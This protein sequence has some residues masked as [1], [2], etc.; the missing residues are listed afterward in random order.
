MQGIAFAGHR[1]GTTTEVE[2][3]LARAFFRNAL[4]LCA[5]NQLYLTDDEQQ[6][7][8]KWLT[9]QEADSPTIMRPDDRAN[10]E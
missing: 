10:D 6:L 5:R 7:V 4:N 9:G 3:E 8:A 2:K 1:L